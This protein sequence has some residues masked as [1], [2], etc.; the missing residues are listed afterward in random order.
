MLFFE[1]STDIPKSQKE[2][3]FLSPEHVGKFICSGTKSEDFSP[4]RNLE[5]ISFTRVL[6]HTTTIS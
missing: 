1:I 3:K 2:K 4:A 6:G 5:I